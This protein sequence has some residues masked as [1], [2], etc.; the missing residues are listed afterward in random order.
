MANF[1]VR[2]G[3]TLVETDVPSDITYDEGST[4]AINA[5]TGKWGLTTT[6]TAKYRIVYTGYP[7]TRPDV[8]TVGK[9]KAVCGPG[10]IET[11]VISG[12]VSTYA[13]GAEVSAKSAMI[14][15][16]DT[17][18]IGFVSGKS[19]TTLTIQLY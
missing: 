4:L 7:S 12:A 8:L 13:Y 5:S 1:Q 14:T 19:A 11:D 10:I 16:L 2:Y 3:C 18:A 9:L 15:A 17:T 6:A